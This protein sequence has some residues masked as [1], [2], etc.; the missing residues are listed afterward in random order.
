[1]NELFRLALV[2]VVAAV[3]SALYFMP[4]EKPADNSRVA[5]EAPDVAKIDKKPITPAKVWVYDDKAKDKLPLPNDIKNNPDEHVF[6]ASK[7]E[8]HT[9]TTMINLTTGEATTIDHKDPLPWLALVKL[10]EL[11]LDY[12]LNGV[13]RLSYRHDIVQIKAFHFGINT[14]LDSNGSYFI[15]AGVGYRF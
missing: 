14:T 12:G 9:V 13:M 8:G 7:V 1:M 2:A 11:R 3:L 5:T 10:N 15:G 4:A 6:A